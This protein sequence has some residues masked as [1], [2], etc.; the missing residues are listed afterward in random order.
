MSNLILRL[1]LAVA[2]QFLIAPSVV[3]AFGV[4]CALLG[5]RM[6]ELPLDWIWPASLAVAVLIMKPWSRKPLFS[7]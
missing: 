1:L 2:L 5:I 3:G 4:S 6:P 7:D